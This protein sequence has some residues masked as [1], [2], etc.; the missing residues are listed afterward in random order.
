[1]DCLVGIAEPVLVLLKG[2][3]RKVNTFKSWAEIKLKKIHEHD[4]YVG[5]AWRQWNW[6]SSGCDSWLEPRAAE[7]KCVLGHWLPVGFGASVSLTPKDRRWAKGVLLY[8]RQLFDLNS[9]FMTLA[10]LLGSWQI[11]TNE[12][13]MTVGQ[14]CPQLARLAKLPW[15]WAGITE[16]NITI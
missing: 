14:F 12:V 8:G 1:M 11:V 5:L 6:D 7:F 4:S 10:L 15:H 13:R 16:R 2:A 3:V 9:K